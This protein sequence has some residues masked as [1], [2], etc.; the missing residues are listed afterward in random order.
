MKVIISGSSGFI[1]SHLSKYLLLFDKEVITSSR[2]NTLDV[3]Y[4]VKSYGELTNL[5]NN[6]NFLVHLAG[7]NLNIDLDINNE[8]E[9]IKELSFAY[10]NKLIYISSATVYGSNSREKIT[11][12]SKINP[13]TSYAKNKLLCEQEVVKNSGIVLRV[14]NVFGPLMSKKSVFFDILKQLYKKDI[15]L[16]N[17]EAERD[18]IFIDDVCN[19]IKNVLNNPCEGIYN[20]SSGKGTSIKNICDTILELKGLDKNNFQ[21]ISKNKRKSTLVIDSS[22]FKKTF[23]WEKT[24]TL[25]KGIEKLLIEE[26]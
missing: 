15:I 22:L 17:F 13:L 2:N 26:V 8:K 5:N 4:R 9:I 3:N 10:K 24:T 19:A 20:V 14:S 23:R 11:E 18:F 16:D 7:S 21:Y 25:K 12:S 1:G 6:S